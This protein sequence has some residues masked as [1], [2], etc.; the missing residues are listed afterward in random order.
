MQHST[1]LTCTQC[2]FLPSSFFPS[3]APSSS[4]V[5]SSPSSLVVSSSSSSSPALNKAD[6]LVCTPEKWDLITRGWR[7]NSNDFAES[8]ASTGKKFIREVGLL[9]IDEIHLLGE[10]RG[11]VLEAIVSRTRLISK[12]IEQ[13]KGKGSEDDKF[14]ATR[15]IGL[16]TALAN[17]CM[18]LS[19][20]FFGRVEGQCSCFFCHSFF[21]LTRRFLK[22]NIFLF[23]ALTLSKPFNR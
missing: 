15:I 20:F 19:S 22:T 5:V 17:P 8:P 13:E 6:V 16:S 9:I 7:G 12:F 4:L 23:F 11:A 10:E 18:Y 1:N 2:N 14:E 21:Y 3:F